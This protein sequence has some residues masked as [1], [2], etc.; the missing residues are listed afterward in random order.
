MHDSQECFFNTRSEELFLFNLLNPN[1]EVL[2]WG[3]GSSTHAI[4]K[5]VRHINSIEHDSKWYNKIADN[6]FNNANIH[7]RSRNQ[8]EVSGHDGTEEDYYDYVHA[9]ETILYDKKVDLIF[10]DGRARVACAKV[11]INFL[12]IGGSIVMHDIFNPDHK[13]DRQEYWEVLQFLHPI[14]GEF[15]MW[16]FKPKR[17]L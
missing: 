15:A 9:P 14:A 17:N 3:S 12:A 13:C 5:R 11:A 4:A 1:M 10:I 2:E 8:T 16:Q 7:Y 6:L